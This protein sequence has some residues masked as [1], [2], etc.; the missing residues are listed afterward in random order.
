MDI[1]GYCQSLN[2]SKN[3]EALYYLLISIGDSVHGKGIPCFVDYKTDIYNT[4][5]RIMRDIASAKFWPQQK[6]FTVGA[7]GI[8][9]VE[10][11]CYERKT[12]EYEMPSK[13]EF[14]KSC[15]EV[16][17][18][19]IPLLKPPIRLPED[20]IPLGKYPTVGVKVDVFTENGYITQATFE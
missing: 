8:C 7:R 11:C 17:L 14:F 1:E 12:S 13:E 4:D 19:F 5:S 2:L 10:C 15:A 16:N 18:E 6:R 9:Y 20:F 3:Y